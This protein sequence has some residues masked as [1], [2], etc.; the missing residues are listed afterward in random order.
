MNSSGESRENGSSNFARKSAS[1]PA[2]SMRLL[3]ERADEPGRAVRGEEADGMRGKS[4]GRGTQ[5][6]F[7]GPADDALQN[8][9]M[10]EVKPVKVSDAHNRGLREIRI[11]E[12]G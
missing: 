12:R 5:A 3:I 6:Q 9:T 4:N 1:M 8:F 2:F 11:G 10:A 7:P